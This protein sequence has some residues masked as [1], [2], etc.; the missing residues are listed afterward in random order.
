M[1]LSQGLTSLSLNLCTCP[2]GT[3][4]VPWPV[5]CL[6]PCPAQENSKWASLPTSINSELGQ[7]ERLRHG[8]P[9]PR[10]NLVLSDTFEKVRVL[11][12][13]ELYLGRPVGIKGPQR[14]RV[15]ATHTRTLASGTKSRVKIDHCRWAPIP[16]CIAMYMLMAAPSTRLPFSN[17]HE[18]SLL[19]GGLA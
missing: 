18:Q 5:I 17:L 15:L 16:I 14:T 12:P 2:M 3:E 11:H 7:A 8:C 6:L 1:T 4:Y 10:S 19:V 9:A 13:S